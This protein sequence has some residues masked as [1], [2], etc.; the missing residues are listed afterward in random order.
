VLI[1]AEDYQRR[2]REL[3]RP[4]I[5]DFVAGGAGAE[6]T[7]AANRRAFEGVRLRPRVLVDVSTCDTR[8]T[9]LGAALDVP[10]GIAP[11][12]YHRLL[13]ADGETG[14]AQAAGEA[15]ALCVVSLFAS[16]TLEE[17]AEAATGPLWLQI[18]WLRR[19]DVLADLVKRATAAGYGAV[20]LTVDAPRIGKRLRDVR[21]GFTVDPSVRAVNLDPELMAASHVGVPGGSAI[22]AHATATFDTAVTWADVAWL[23]DVSDLPIVVK[24]V[25]T[26]E[27]A[28]RAV[29]CGVAGI[30]VSNHGG[31]QLDRAIPSLHALPEIAAAVAGACPV[32][33]DGGVRDGGDVFAA[34]ALGADAVLVGR[35]ALWALAVGGG[36]EVG[37]L[38]ATLAE[39]LEHTMALA[40][41]PKL[42][43]IDRSAVVV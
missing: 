15:G 24:G 13:H 30:V 10:I 35:P 21:N 5:W 32:L 12:A 18:Y 16:Q 41:R 39:D 2:A 37:R 4:E 23:R 33:L 22:A 3:L 34:L 43:D 38:L 19:R 27:D 26:A 9:L 42:A 7:V 8:T 6:L 1:C 11:M 14:T 29:E 28:E 17:I 20:V 40:G 31:R 25:L 36:P